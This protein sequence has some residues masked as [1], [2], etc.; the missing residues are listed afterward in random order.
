MKYGVPKSLYEKYNID[1]NFYPIIKI[2]SDL[3][4]IKEAIPPEPSKPVEPKIDLPKEPI[5]PQMTS[6]GKNVTSGSNFWSSTGAIL[7]TII[8]NGFLIYIA[9]EAEV[10]FIFLL[11]G[12]L[13]VSLPFLIS[14]NRR[15]KIKDRNSRDEA[16][17]KYLFEKEQYPVKLEKA[18]SDHKVKLYEY[19]K[20]LKEYNSYNTKVSK[21]EFIAKYRSKLL[22][23]FYGTIKKPEVFN[24]VYNQG[25]SESYFHGYLIKYFGDYVYVNYTIIDNNYSHINLHSD[26]YKPDF[27]FWD[28]ESIIIDIEVDEPYIIT[29]GE[30]IH[31]IGSDD[32]RNDFFTSNNW[33]VLR[34]SEQQIVNHPEACCFQIADIVYD[35][36]GNSSFK[37]N[38]IEHC[39]L[40]PKESMW[41]KEHAHR[42]AYKKLRDRWLSN[43]PVHGSSNLSNK[44]IHT[45]KTN[46]YQEPL[47]NSTNSNQNSIYYESVFELAEGKGF[48]VFEVGKITFE[49]VINELGSDYELLKHRQGLLKELSYEKIGV[50]FFRMYDSQRIYRIDFKYPFQGITTRGIELYKS[51]A[52]DVFYKYKYPTEKLEWKTG[53]KMDHWY[54]ECKGITFY[55]DKDYA[56]PDHPFNEQVYLKKKIVKITIDN[57]DGVKK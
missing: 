26:V 45:S 21:H 51:T 25:K 42:M 19:E 53:S 48:S 35:L 12:I 30:P 23:D 41:T 6:S 44:S 8:F 34:F 5:S 10:Y 39:Y 46:Y 13:I 29:T 37:L 57:E 22:K 14:S 40:P 33:I 50:S 54:I 32:R 24:G 16:Y 47:T 17:K 1:D 18:H 56:I 9:V 31:Y 38:L 11:Y 43:L 3:L 15:E 27:I 7:A 2:P 52:E 20:A 49:D 55:V 28:E 4:N 36:T